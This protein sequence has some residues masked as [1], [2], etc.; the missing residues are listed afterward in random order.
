[1]SGIESSATKTAAIMHDYANV[2]TGQHTSY[3][4]NLS[5]SSSQDF[6]QRSNTSPLAP[7]NDT[8]GISQK[9]VCVLAFMEALWPTTGPAKN[10]L[11]FACRAAVAPKSL[12]RVS[13]A[14]ATYHRG[15]GPISND[16]VL[17]CQ[18]A[19]LEIHIIHERFR[20]DLAVVPA[21]RNL[22]ARCKP[23]I[24]QS[25]AVKSHFLIRLAAIHRECPWIAF[26]HG[27]TWTS[28]RTRIY[29]QFDR[30][31]LRAACKVV[32]VC[33]LFAS[34]LEEI[35]VRPERIVVRHNSVKNFSPAPEEVVVLLRRTLGISENTQVLLCVGRLSREKAQADLIEAA[36]LMR[37]D[38]RHGNVRFVIAGDGPDRQKLKD[39]TRAFLVE[40]WFIF[41]GQV[42]DLVP[43]YTMADLVVLPSHTEGSPNVLLEAMAAGV[44]IV[45]T[46]VGGVPEIV[47][48][49][50]QALLVE[51]RNP[52]ALARAIERLL[53]NANLRKR[54]SEAARQSISSYSPEAYYD[55]ILSLY[56]SCLAGKCGLSNS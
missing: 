16:F 28:P 18:K 48:D 6:T 2:F 13:I 55:S 17:A 43:Y 49:E 5:L 41:T 34:A 3:S 29:N 37:R 21:I 46:D 10:L 4:R 45:A 30:W 51:K 42:A 19:G 54:L 56:L 53:D 36:A 24:I 40:D 39:M 11:E 52:V 44:P 38:G 22:F 35:G 20:F 8:S 32:T 50:K 25:H 14:I 15:S 23:D 7:G 26:H 27:Y 47:E 12:S 9:P 31:S 1:M 33:R